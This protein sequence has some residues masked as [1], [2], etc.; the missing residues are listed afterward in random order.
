MPRANG[1]TRQQILLTMKQDGALTADELAKELGISPV[2]VR[3]HLA[4][5]EA[6]GLVAVRVERKGLGRPSHR[7]QLT[8][9]GDETFPR[10]YDR[11]ALALLS[12]LTAWQGDGAIGELVGRQNARQIEAMLPRLKGCAFGAKLDEIVRMFNER[13]DMAEAEE[14][15]DGSYTLVKRNC[16]ICSLAR[17]MPELCCAGETELL[18][19]LLD[20]AEVTLEQSFP[21]GDS[22]CRFR[23][24]P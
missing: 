4:S 10:C 15:D 11:F 1:I 19:T 2:A 7:Y 18:S 21:E 6:E 13:G 9:D 17:Q 5:M 3:Q 22:F 12:E 16:P 8:A 23:I 14:A 24:D 20:G